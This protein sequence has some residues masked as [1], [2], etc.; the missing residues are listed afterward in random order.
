MSERIGSINVYLCRVC[1]F[2]EG[3]VL[4]NTGVTGF[5]KKCFNCGQLE[6]Y[7]CFYHAQVREISLVAFRPRDISLYPEW[8]SHVMKGGLIFKQIGE[9]IDPLYPDFQSEDLD[10]WKQYALL[11]YGQIVLGYLT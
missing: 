10:D 5:C 7:S 2:R 8:T 1:G 4:L 6:S 9:H 11:H 3:V